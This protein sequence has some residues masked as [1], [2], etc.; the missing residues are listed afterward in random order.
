V[1]YSPLMKIGAFILLFHMNILRSITCICLLVIYST[2]SAQNDS[3]VCHCSNPDHSAP[4]GIFNDHVHAKKEWMLS[5]RYMLMNMRGSQQGRTKLS[6]DQVYNN[7]IMAPSRMNMQMH[8]LMLM[9]GLSDRITLMGMSSFVVNTMDM[10]MMESGNPGHIHTGS[11]DH[12]QFSSQTSGITDTRI[13]AV[14]ELF[15][16][17]RDDLILSGGIN[18]PTGKISLRG[19]SMTKENDKL[20]YIMQPGTGNFAILPGITYTW[21]R[22]ISGGMQLSAVLRTGKNKLSYRWGHEAGISGWVSHGWNGWLSSSIRANLT[23]SERIIGFDPEVAIQRSIDP[24]ADINNYGGSR[25]AMYGGAS[26]VL[27]SGI[28]EGLRIS[29]EYGLPFYQNLNG[30]QMTLRSTLYTSIQYGF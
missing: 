7:Y 16:R 12:E 20:P 11:D 10:S 17:D 3:S 25:A 2:A 9:Y 27:P 24:A 30:V 8:M 28:L 1:F 21:Q 26:I 19:S 15:S 13:Y 4:A 14:Y 5:Y 23:V 29:A 18:L 6:Q 22:D